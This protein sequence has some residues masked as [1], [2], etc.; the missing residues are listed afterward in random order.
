VPGG[1]WVGGNPASRPGGA[2]DGPRRARRAPRAAP[3]PIP[4]PSD[5]LTGEAQAIGK[6]PRI[7][8]LR[9]GTLPDAFVDFRQ[10]LRELGYTEGFK[11][12]RPA[13][14]PI[15]QAATFELVINLRAAKAL[16]LTI[17]QSL[18]LRADEVIR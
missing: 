6:I 3:L 12:A 14:L 16:G 5:G 18:L 4:P 15:E 17:P 2:R 7:G 1:C 10:G 13:D 11:G 8:I 9:S